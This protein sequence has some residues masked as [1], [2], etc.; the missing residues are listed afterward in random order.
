MLSGT[1]PFCCLQPR[2]GAGCFHPQPVGP[3]PMPQARSA[4]EVPLPP[5]LGSQWLHTLQTGASLSPAAQIIQLLRWGRVPNSVATSMFHCWG[6]RERNGFGNMGMRQSHA[7][8]GQ[9]FLKR[10]AQWLQVAQ[11]SRQMWLG[12][13]PAAPMSSNTE[14]EKVSR[15][16]GTS[17]HSFRIRAFHQPLSAR[18]PQLKRQPILQCLTY[19]R[20]EHR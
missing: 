12:S 10:A 13:V 6:F 16:D 14:E 5:V 4:T 18:G 11:A 1:C 9:L 20:E 19:E 2:D 3:V 17:P 7:G 8:Q 15:A